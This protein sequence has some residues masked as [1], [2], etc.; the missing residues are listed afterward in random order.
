MKTSDTLTT[1]FR[2][3]LWANLRL[4]ERCKAFSD[5]QLDTTVTGTYGSIRDTFQHLVLAEKGYSSRI[6]TGQRYYHPKDAKPMTFPDMKESLQQTGT[7]LIEWA[8]KVQAADT[9]PIDWDGT[10]RGVPKTILLNQVINHATEHR[11]Q[12]MVIMTQLGIEPPSLD[13]WTYFDELDQG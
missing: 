4:L 1:I 5:T 9:V 13:S 6:S 12:I 2:H 8:Q 7:E 11:A 10:M 3:N